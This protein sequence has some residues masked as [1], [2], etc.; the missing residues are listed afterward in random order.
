MKRSLTVHRT[1]I[2][3][4]SGSSVRKKGQPPGKQLVEVLHLFTCLI[5]FLLRSNMHSHLTSELT[6]DFV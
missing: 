5:I 6:I 1:C 2:Y 3:S 4:L